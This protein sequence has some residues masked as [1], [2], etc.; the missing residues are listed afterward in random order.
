MQTSLHF[1][2]S[3]VDKTLLFRANIVANFTVLGSLNLILSTLCP[4]LYSEKYFVLQ[5]CELHLLRKWKDYLSESPPIHREENKHGKYWMY[6]HRAT[7]LILFLYEVSELRLQKNCPH[8]HSQ[9]FQSWD[10]G[11]TT[12]PIPYHYC[13]I[14]NVIVFPWHAVYPSQNT[15]LS[16]KTRLKIE[17]HMSTDFQ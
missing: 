11:K 7:P 12:K 13:L 6:Q 9:P 3:T 10:M 4:P 1:S 5:S 14:Q 17:E 8:S 2:L 16:C 15:R